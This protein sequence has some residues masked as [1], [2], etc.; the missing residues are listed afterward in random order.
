[1]LSRPWGINLGPDGALYIADHDNGRVRRLGADGIIK[2][3]AGGGSAPTGYGGDGGPA[4]KAT[5]FSPQGVAVAPD[6][7]LLIADAGNWRIRLVKPT[8]PQFALG[9]IDIPSDDGSQLY[10]F[11]A[12]GR[13]LSTLDALTG[14]AIYRFAYNAAGLLASITDRAGNVTTIQHDG[15]GHPSAIV[16]PY[17]QVTALTVD[18]NGYLASIADP[19]NETTLLA[20]TA[21][22]LLTSYTDPSGNAHHFVYDALG[23]LATNQDPL[24]GNSTLARVETSSAYS[25]TF[26]SPMSRTTIYA[27]ASSP[28][29]ASCRSRPCRRA[30]ARAAPAAPTAPAA[31]RCPTA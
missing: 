15:A 8:L 26:A 22:G 24:G 21:D 16:S 12:G 19:A 29:A 9:N 7:T 14:A 27:T 13:H 6:G 1:M 25:V 23:R 17:G 11:D 2:T 31:C 5:L 30:S 10:V 20:S 4:T 3:V 28:A 18:A